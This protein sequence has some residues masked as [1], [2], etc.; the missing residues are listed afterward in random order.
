MPRPVVLNLSD[1]QRSCSK[2]IACA[3]AVHLHEIG[4]ER[5][6]KIKTNRSPQR[7][8]AMKFLHR[9]CS[10]SQATDGEMFCFCLDVGRRCTL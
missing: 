2:P 3:C 6:P 5:L 1:S 8:L 7:L 4:Q 10:V 9:F